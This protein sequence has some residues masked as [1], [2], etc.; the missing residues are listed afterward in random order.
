MSTPVIRILKRDRG[1]GWMSVDLVDDDGET[2]CSVVVPRFGPNHR[3]G[4]D[5]WCHPFEEDGV[6]HHE[7]CH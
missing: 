3:A 4:L 1:P 2:F 5:C 7:A 6:I